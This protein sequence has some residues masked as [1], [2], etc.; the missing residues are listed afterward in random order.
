MIPV[1]VSHPVQWAA[2]M[3]LIPPFFVTVLFCRLFL[4]FFKQPNI[5]ARN[6]VSLPIP[7]ARFVIRPNISFGLAAFFCNF[8]QTKVTRLPFDQDNPPGVSG[9][10]PLF[11]PALPPFFQRVLIPLTFPFFFFFM[12]RDPLKPLSRTSTPPNFS[13]RHF[14]FPS[15]DPISV[16][17]VQ[18]IRIHSRHYLSSTFFFF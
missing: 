4:L 8:C 7:S 3:N 12:S 9:F 13:N 1:L 17:G 2:P 6:S 10:L 18:N 14:R 11:R 15:V 16:R 5:V